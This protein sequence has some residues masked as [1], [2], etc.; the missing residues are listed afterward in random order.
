MRKRIIQYLSEAPIA[1]L[2]LLGD[3]TK[4]S[5]FRHA[6]D[7]KLLTNPKAIEKIKSAW[8][9]PD[10]VEFN[11]MLLNHKSG[12]GYSQIGELTF[13]AFAKDWPEIYEQCRD[14]L[15]A[16]AVN[17]LYL[18]NSGAPRHPMTGWIMAHRMG[19][20]LLGRSSSHYMKEADRRY[21]DYVEQLAEAYRLPRTFATGL[22]LAGRFDNSLLAILREICTFRSARMKKIATPYEGFFELFAQYL[23]TGGIKLNTPPAHVQ[24]NRA[25]YSLDMQ[26]IPEH[27]FETLMHDMAYELKSYFE[28]ALHYAAGKIIIM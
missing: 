9:G 8:K 22:R 14:S 6:Q 2:S 1:D 15:R 18:N 19:H 26:D 13:E 28:T 12:I 11:V 17:V 20:A 10:E 21:W 24:W 27:H 16:D 3:W 25:Y 4:S 23:I 5:S 7:R